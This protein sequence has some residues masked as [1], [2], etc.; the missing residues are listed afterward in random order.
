MAP[1]FECSRA[2]FRP[3]GDDKMPPVRRALRPLVLLLLV[4]C[5]PARYRA[6]ALLAGTGAVL[7]GGGAVAFAAGDRNDERGAE[8]AGAL[9][10]ALGL[11]ALLAAGIWAATRATCEVDAD[12]A[13]T[14]LCERLFTT[15]GPYGQCK[16]R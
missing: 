4:S 14:E 7:A 1:R 11:G 16:A 10:L 2:P 13:E 3:K 8:T 9:S 12:C 6:P 15:A 5:A